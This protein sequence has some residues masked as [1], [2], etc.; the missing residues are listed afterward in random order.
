[1]RGTAYK[2]QPFGPGFLVGAAF[3]GPGTVLT[4][5][6]AGAEF[7]FSLLWALLFSLA[8]TFVLQEMALRLGLVKRLALTTILRDAIGQPLLKWLLLSLVVVAIVVG[9]SAYEGGNLTG[10]AA[11]AQL[12]FGGHQS[13]WVVLLAVTSGG[14]LFTGRYHLFERLLVGLV[15]LM[16]VMF[17][18]SAVMMMLGSDSPKVVQLSSQPPSRQQFLTL[19][20]IG[21]TVVPYNLFLHASLVQS[22]WRA[23]VALDEALRQARLDLAISMCVGGVVTLSVMATAASL[24]A[25]GQSLE[26]LTDLP[27]QLAP[28]AGSFAS[29]AFAVGLLAAGLSSA[30]TAPL[31]AALTLE[32]VIHRVSDPST[33]AFRATWG[34]VIL[35]GTVLAVTSHQPV[36]LILV[37]QVANALLLP[38]LAMVMIYLAARADLMGPQRNLRWQTGVGYV[39]VAVCAYLSAQRFL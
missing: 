5:S 29:V 1:M 7:G 16:A 10:A 33:L 8:L 3:I 23:G 24:A 11:G 15:A 25:S 27:A 17:A 31:A 38:L 12:L 34:L 4:A 37:A 22:K 9:N 14:L 39:A 21:T 28:V 6:R 19:A 13:V 35:S 26:R 18:L 2:A 32:G 36:E 30:L 20:L